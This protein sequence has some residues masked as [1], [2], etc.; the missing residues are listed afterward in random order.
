MLLL[1]HAV[2]NIV[3]LRLGSTELFSGLIQVLNPLLEYPQLPLTE[4]IIPP[5]LHPQYLYSLTRDSI[6]MFL[7]LYQF[8]SPDYKFG[9]SEI[10][11][12][13]FSSFW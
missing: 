3:Y 2:K 10:L 1:P 7:C 11:E 13:L 5:S 8:L 12:F 9:G 4:L 6:V